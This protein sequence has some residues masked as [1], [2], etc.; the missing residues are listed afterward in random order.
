MDRVINFSD[1]VFAIAITLLVLNFRVPHVTGPDI[2]RKLLDALGHDGGFLIGYALSFFVIAR[3]WMAHHRLSL[4]LRHVDTGF[5]VLNFVFLAFVVFV[6]FPTEVLGTY[7]ETTTAV[8]FYAGSMVATGLLSWATWEYALRRGLDGRQASP[9]QRRESELRSLVL[10]AV[11]AASIP[12]AFAD[13]GAAKL[14]WVLLVVQHPLAR[15]FGVGAPA[16]SGAPRSG[17]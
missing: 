10:V 15:R 5:I 2:N 1:G 17:R 8:V 13:P 3:Y 7:S 16:S 9:E 14:V 4:L 6:P 11:F 12:I